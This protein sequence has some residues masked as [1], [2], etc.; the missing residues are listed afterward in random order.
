MT[1]A[2]LRAVVDTLLPA[3]EGLPSGTG[4]GVTRALADQNVHHVLAAIAAR[5]GGEAS[6][7]AADE[8]TRV[9]TLQG[10]S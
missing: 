10:V 7:V 4:A 2:F 5:S 6:F 8:P 3:D 1:E 9:A